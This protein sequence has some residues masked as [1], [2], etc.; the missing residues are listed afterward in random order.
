MF[1]ASANSQPRAKMKIKILSFY[2]VPEGWP[3]DCES[4]PDD[5]E[6]QPGETVLTL[7]EFDALRAT[8][9]PA[10]DAWELSPANPATRSRVIAE[11]KS[12][13]QSR[14]IAATGGGEYWREKQTNMIARNSE[15]LE[16]EIVNGSLTPQEAGE[17]SAL[18][19]F[20]ARVKAIRAHSGQIE[21]R[22]LAGE[23]IDIQAG[24]P[25]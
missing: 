22:F 11:I 1:G 13:A 15:L 10:Y 24:W 4:V 21:A 8:L 5:Y 19:A 3:K 25:A 9:Q 23:K 2:E 12:E 17:R 14:I 16:L 6:P 7:A 18:K 20:W